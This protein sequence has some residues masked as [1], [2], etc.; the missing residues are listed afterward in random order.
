MDLADGKVEIA[1]YDNNFPGQARAVVVDTAKETWSYSTATNPA[2]PVGLYEGNAE[3]FS[4]TITPTT[5][6]LEPQACP[7]CGGDGGTG[8]ARGSTKGA[9]ASGGETTETTAGAEGAESGSGYGFVFLNDSGDEGGVDLKITD[10]D[11]KPLPGVMEISTKSDSLAQD[12]A[13]PVIMVPDGTAFK[14]TIDG[15]N[16]EEEAETDVT[17]VADGI[18]MYIDDIKVDPGQI[19]E[20]IIDPAAGSISYAT[21]RTEAPTIGAGFSSDAADYA[22]AIGG[23][24]LP[25]GGIVTMTLDQTAGTFT[26]KNEDEVAGTYAIGMLRID[27]EG[28]AT[29]TDDGFELPAQASVSLDYNDWNAANE[30][31]KVTVDAGDGS[32]PTE[33]EL[34]SD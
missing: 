26:I 9:S 28:E 33:A 2:E 32:A 7:F 19:D 6:R 27:D 1:I 30:K 17:Y 25:D 12:D 29:F 14:I 20:A 8:A 22:F 5:A 31:L 3:T 13:P 16:V 21:T 15:T 10:L 34:E 24:D 18:D 11:G 4:L 23:V